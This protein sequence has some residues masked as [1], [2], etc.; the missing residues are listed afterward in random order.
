MSPRPASISRTPQI[1][2]LIREEQGG[3]AEPFDE[4]WHLVKPIDGSREWA[5]AGIQQYA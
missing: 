3:V 5:I 4:V 1:D 2:G